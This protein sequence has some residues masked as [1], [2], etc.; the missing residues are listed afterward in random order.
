MMLRKEQLDDESGKISLLYDV[1]FQVFIRYTLHV[2]GIRT[3]FY[4]MGVKY[5]TYFKLVLYYFQEKTDV[6]CADNIVGTLKELESHMS[7]HF[8]KKFSTPES[9]K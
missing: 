9:S 1:L 7:S 4:K 2:L 5:H 3:E 6:T 8:I